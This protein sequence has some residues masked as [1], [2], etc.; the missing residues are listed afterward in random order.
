MQGNCPVGS[1][2]L[3]DINPYLDPSCRDAG[4]VNNPG[5]DIEN[6]ES[7]STAVL[8]IQ[9]PVKCKHIRGFS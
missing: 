4:A 8:L 3:S 1:F 7:T 5:D 2:L 6:T 9:N